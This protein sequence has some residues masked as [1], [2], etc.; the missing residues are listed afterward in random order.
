MIDINQVISQ[1]IGYIWW[2]IPFAAL[3]LLVKSPWFKGLVGEWIVNLCAALFLPSKRYVRFHNVTLPTLD[4]T[5]QIDHIFVSRFGVFVV[6]TKNMTGWIFGSER[7]RQWTQK[8]FKQSFK[9]QNPLRQNYKHA[10][11]LETELKIPADT[12]HSVV[13]FIGGATFKTEMPDNVTYIHELVS[14]I[15]SFKTHVFSCSEVDLIRDRIT[16]R[17]LKP[18]LKT[19]WTH[20]RNLRT[21]S[22]PNAQRRSRDASNK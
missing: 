7:Q 13:V 17:R 15:K 8:I 12:I 19:N 16:A 2:L 14:Y 21:R 18:S 11:V 22:D 6:E 9:F 10:K 4:G 20:V 3:I 1:F 5:T